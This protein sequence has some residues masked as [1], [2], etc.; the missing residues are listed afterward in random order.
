MAWYET[1]PLNS[2]KEAVYFL[3]DALNRSIDVKASHNPRVKTSGHANV[4]TKD[5]SALTESS[6]MAD[7]Y[8]SSYS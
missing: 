2:N 3:I 4:T 7:I 5:I 6:S 8:N 1:G